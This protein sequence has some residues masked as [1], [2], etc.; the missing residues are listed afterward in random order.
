MLGAGVTACGDGDDGTLELGTSCD[1]GALERCDLRERGCWSAVVEYTACIRQSTVPADLPVVVVPADNV[2]DALGVHRL[3]HTTCAT[4]AGGSLTPARDALAL[5][6]LTTRAS[7]AAATTGAANAAVFSPEAKAVLIV[8]RGAPLESASDATAL[9]HAFVHAL[10]DRELGVRAYLGRYSETPDQELAAAAA[11]D[12][13]AEFYTSVLELTL[14]GGAHWS[15]PRPGAAPLRERIAALGSPLCDSPRLLAAHYGRR[16]MAAAWRRSAQ[17]AIAA[18]L[19]APPGSTAAL[20]RGPPKT[21][22]RTEALEIPLSAPLAGYRGVGAVGL[23]QWNLL[24][25][26][27]LA[28]AEDPE[29]A[30]GGWRGDQF[31]AFTRTST[32]PG[33]RPGAAYVWIVE[34][35][36]AAS[37]T[38][39]EVAAMFDTTRSPR[40]PRLAS[41][42]AHNL[43][44]V[45]AEQADR[46]TDWMDAAKAAL[47]AVP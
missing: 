33:Q 9:A 6:D 40:F 12:G 4:T 41:A 11:L 21:S 27:S 43:V 2:P 29:G 5:T 39:A 46:L 15:G 19:L 22:T 34:W 31:H 45:G 7:T 8:D 20:I 17:A 1:A 47:T 16:L 42:Q 3:R 44:L 24:M 13:E 25:A 28:G 18:T 32:A 23:G 14:Y 26:L 35:D 30:S 37:P 36:A 10:Q 38:A